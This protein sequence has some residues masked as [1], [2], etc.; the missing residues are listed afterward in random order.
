M[1]PI[2]TLRNVFE[3]NFASQFNNMDTLSLKTF[4]CKNFGPNIFGFFFAL[5]VF[6]RDFRQLLIL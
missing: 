6:N 2:T 1:L 5:D 3:N 4:G